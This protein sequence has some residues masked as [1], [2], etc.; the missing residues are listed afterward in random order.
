MLRVGLT[1]GMGSG[2]STVAKIFS[3]MGAPVY[4]AD[5]AAKRLMQHDAELK[6]QLIDIFGEELYQNGK[7]DRIWLAAKV[8][9]DTELLKK[10]NSVVHPATIRDGAEWMLSQHFAYAIKEAALI[11]ESG[12]N[13]E[14][15]FVIGVR[16][17]LELRMERI[18]KR[19][20]IS[21]DAIRARMN[22]QMPEDEKMKLCDAV[23][24][25]DEANLLIPQVLQLHQRFINNSKKG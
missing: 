14:L 7:L 22:K 13:R 3:V 1:G 2:K 12:S 25:N 8:F 16:S 10:L 19:D 20:N 11:F 18:R 15:D 24:E 21:D 5:A 9:N 6:Q 4:D 23:I 17:P